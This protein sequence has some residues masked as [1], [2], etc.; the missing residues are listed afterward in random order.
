MKVLVSGAGGFVGNV[1]CRQLLYKG[2]QVVA[3]DNFH[4]GQCDALIPLV[5]NDNF[6]F[7][8]GDVTNKSDVTK[9]M[10]GIDGII[11]LAAIVGVPACN[12][13]PALAKAVNVEGTQ[14]I[15]N[16]KSQDMPIVY[17]ST[18]SVY[19]AVEGTCTERSP[20]NTNTLYGITKLNAEKIIRDTTNSVSLRF[21]TGFGLSPCMRVNL[22][23]NDF[24]YRAKNEG[25]LT[26]F[27]KSF[28]RTFIH[29]TDMARALIFSLEH[30]KTFK[31][32]VYN[33]GDNNLNWTKE[34]LSEYVKE[35]TGCYVSYAEF[36]TDADLRDY[37]CDF[38]LLNEEGFFC[39]VTMEE[40]I[41]E[42]I[43]ATP[44]L[45]IRHQYE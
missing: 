44:L 4:K 28:R 43:K 23:V 3:F 34:Q 29:V 26:V 7:I 35:R 14:N 18:G 30:N 21:A 42:L 36:G 16:A 10:S 39:T 8:Y 12:R 24:V 33:C 13:H 2:H 15:V 1:L 41:D 20:T 6:S 5:S 45:Q 9:A 40:G 31:N 27:Q 22:L 37:A 32:D 38:S 19:G 17:A 11:H 25:C